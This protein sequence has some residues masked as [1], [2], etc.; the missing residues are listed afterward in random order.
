MLS[1]LTI[2]V[3]SSVL[4]FLMLGAASALRCRA[5]A[6]GGIARATGNRDNL[7]EPTPLA[8]R[9]DRAAKNMVENL[10]LFTALAAALYFAGKQ[11]STL[12]QIGANIFFWMRIA[13]WPIY[14]AGNGLRSVVWTISIVGLGMIAWAA[15]F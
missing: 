3:L 14:L 8:A 15:L 10:A 6:P 1:L 9:A 2:L 13:Y 11:G 5:F 7:P 4:C 12:A